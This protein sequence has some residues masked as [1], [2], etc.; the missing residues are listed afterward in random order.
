MDKALIFNW[1]KTVDE[2][3]TVYI[4]GDFV[5][6]TGKVADYCKQLKGHKVLILGNHDRIKGPDRRFFDGIYDYL[7]IKDNGFNVIMSH[8]PMLSY[9]KDYLDTSIHLFGHV[10]NSTKESQVVQEIFTNLRKIYSGVLDNR[11][12]AINVGC[13]MPWIDYIPRSIDY[14]VNKLDQG[15]IYEA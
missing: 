8:Y 3:D 2:D 12:Q 15:E 5:W 7:E 13:M 11:C 1:N 14:L 6:K 4:L 9:N 10:H